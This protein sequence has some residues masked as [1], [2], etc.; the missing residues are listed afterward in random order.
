MPTAKGNVSSDS[1]NNE[2]HD[3]M[4]V[5]HSREHRPTAALKSPYIVAS[6]INTTMHSKQ[7]L[8]HLGS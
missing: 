6:T 7:G 8:R 3:G 2:V 4:L 1:S 5:R